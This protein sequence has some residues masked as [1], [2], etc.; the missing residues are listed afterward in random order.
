MKRKTWIVAAFLAVAVALA[1]VSRTGSHPYTLSVV[2]PAADGTIAGT[3]VLIGGEPVGSV[4]S[5]GVQGNA[6]RLTLQFDGTRLPLHAGSTARINWN[7]V[8]GRREVEIIPGP[9]ANPVLPSGYIVQS[10]TERVELSDLLDTLNGPTRTKVHQLVASLD[11]ALQG[12]ESSL[13]ATLK[14]AGPL[15]STLG[16][17][18]TDVGADQPAIN[19]I[20]G[21]VNQMVTVL[22]NRNSST[23]DTVS[24]LTSLVHE[25]AGREQQLAQALDQAPS[26]LA[27]ATTF[28]NDVPG[29]ANAAIPLLNNLRGTADQ[30]P[31][32][33]KKLNPV[34]T[35]LKPT[36]ADLRPTMAAARSLLGETPAL[37]DMGTAT[38]P[39]I[40]AA[41]SQLQP[42]V[43]FLRPYTPEVIGFLSNW[44]SL[45]SAKNSAGHF[46]R[47]LIPVSASMFNDNPGIVPPGL[48]QW[49]TPAP[50]Q[51]VGQPWTDANGD[52]VR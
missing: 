6:A 10:T 48:S 20:V 36:I 21:K 1:V 42:A 27:A 44:A 51:L 26:T 19:S 13:D 28:F 50:G 33:A 37:L 43:S 32:L 49:Q 31:S 16:S 3:S 18:V 4:T 52:T 22:A 5:V 40:Q 9:A 25:V 38:V 41:L 17:V 15:V 45:F 23:A 7:S 39:A 30:L 29:A 8:L 24:R 2:M 35:S 12:N 11:Q 34:L 47:A 46:G 14:A